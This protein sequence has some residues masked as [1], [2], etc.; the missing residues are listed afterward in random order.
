MKAICLPSGD[1]A[2]KLSRPFVVRR[3]TPDPSR[4]M[5]KIPA[6]SR[7]NAIRFP[8]GENAGAADGYLPFVSCLR[9][10]PDGRDPEDL[11]DPEPG[12]LGGEHDPL[13]LS[14]RRSRRPLRVSRSSGGRPPG[15]ARPR[16]RSRSAHE[17]RSQCRSADVRRGASPR[18]GCPCAVRPSGT[19]SN[20]HRDPHPERRARRPSERVLGSVGLVMIGCDETTARA[21]RSALA[22]CALAVG[23]AIAALIVTSGGHRDA[24]CVDN[25]AAGRRSPSRDPSVPIIGG[26]IP[27]D[28]EPVIEPKDFSTTLTF[29]PGKHRY[30]IT[31]SN[32][33]N[34]GAINSF[35]WY[36]PT[37]AHIVKL[38]GSTAGQ[39]HPPGPDGFRRQPVPGA[40][41]ASE[42]PLRQAR[43]QAPELHL[44]RRRRRRDD[45][46][47][48]RQGIR[49]GRCR[50]QGARGD[51]RLPPHPRV[52]RHGG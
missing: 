50:P 52:L 38:L 48:H 41:P 33:S 8:S 22:A 20:N 4:F 45:L 15:R 2:G 27:V 17:A 5:L 24:A 26:G 35:Q 9:P 21:R 46:V 39:L 19:H 44:P 3:R 43:S 6:P 10:L 32:V 31:I 14:H 36:P 47:R 13:R 30:R 18:D 23:G 34:L 49:R 51:S 7:A 40:R 37:G 25:R 29:L 16:R 1:H 12:W 42:R 28:L 11:L